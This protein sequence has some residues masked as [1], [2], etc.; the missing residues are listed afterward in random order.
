[1]CPT[2]PNQDI[3]SATLSL[4]NSGN[5][6]A[7]WAL[8]AANGDSYADNAA[9]VTSKNP[10]AEKDRLYSELIKY[11]WI[12]TVG[13]DA[14]NQYFDQVAQQHAYNYIDIIQDKNRLPTTTEIAESYANSLLSNGISHIASFDGAWEI[15]GLGNYWGSLLGMEDCRI[16]PTSQAFEDIP[17][18]IGQMAIAQDLIDL[19]G[20]L[21]NNG[22]NGL[23][24]SIPEMIEGILDRLSAGNYG[25]DDLPIGIVE[26]LP[27]IPDDTS[28][29]CQ[30]TDIYY[31]LHYITE[32]M[33][34]LTDEISLRQ[35]I[36]ISAWP[37]EEIKNNVLE[38]DNDGSIH[39]ATFSYVVNQLQSDIEHMEGWVDIN[40]TQL[41]AQF[42]NY[43]SPIALDLDNDGFD[44]IPARH[45]DVYFDIDGDLQL[46][47]T[48]WLSGD[49]GFLAYD[50]NSN[51]QID[52]VHELFGGIDRGAGYAKLAE[53]DSNQDGRIDELDEKYGQL[54]VWQDHNQ[55]GRSDSGELTLLKDLGV[56]SLDLNYTSTDIYLK[57]NL[58]GEI[59][60]ATINDNK[61]AM[62]D[63]YFQYTENTQTNL[64]P[65]STVLL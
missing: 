52:G 16:G 19:A 17:T 56:T 49:D 62:A 3:I 22:I 48:G 21:Y 26:I 13:E 43:A 25:Y 20:F 57:G 5:I 29:Q 18:T 11:H 15:A 65:A 28:G 24:A 7:A 32:R 45:S 14:Y 44:L 31:A 12:N 33:Y 1:M 50:L 4:I 39:S 10:G 51:Q 2:V 60:S 47:L 30:S 61:I 23:L 8:L 35:E 53:L 37:K 40:L 6:S 58:V 42:Y 41:H 9:A 34:R 63:I 64:H 38:V 36:E 59:S 54:L 55:N 27:L 46:E